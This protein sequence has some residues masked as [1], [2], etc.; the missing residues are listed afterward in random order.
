MHKT[1]RRPPL[2]YFLLLFTMVF[3]YA[4]L[5]LILPSAFPRF[6][7]QSNEASAFL[8][9]FPLLLSSAGVLLYDLNLWHWASADALWGILLLL[10]DG[11]G[12]YGIGMRG[13][14]LDGALPQYH[15]PLA[16]LMIAGLLLVMLLLQALTLLLKRAL[17]PKSMP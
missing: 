11:K 13:V 3:L 4:L 8:L 17:K 10:Y 12:L 6:Y 1:F 7:P 5:F 15:R 14:R 2:Q 16:A 9:I